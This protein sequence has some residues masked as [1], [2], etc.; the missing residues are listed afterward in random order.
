MIEELH[1]IARAEEVHAHVLFH[2]YIPDDLL[3]HYYWA[4]DVFALSSRYEPFGMTAIEAMACGTPTVITTH[5][6]LWEE[7][8]WGLDALFADPEDP[9]HFGH[10]ICC[11]LMHPGVAGSLARHGPV[12]ASGN[13]TWSQVAQRFLRAVEA[14][15]GRAKAS[16]EYELAETLETDIDF[17]DRNIPWLARTS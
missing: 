2:D 7:I 17:Y 10:A 11:V 4:A 16:H 1:E 14:P 3:P 8:D 6:G 5:G 13:Y 9:E 12:K 15:H